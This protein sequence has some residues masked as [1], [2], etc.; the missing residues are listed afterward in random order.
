MTSSA[1]VKV[2]VAGL[3]AEMVREIGLR[4]RDVAISEF[5]NAQQMGRAAAHG[6]AR[7]VILSDVMPTED[8]IYVARRAKDASDDMGIAFLISMQQAENALHALK[9]I[10]VD[11]F[12]LVPVDMEEM[13]LE[14]SKMARVEL[15]PPHESHAEQIASAFFAAWERAKP[16]VFQK[17]DRLDD[18]AISLLDD[19]LSPAQAKAAATEAKSVGESATRFGF[20]VA[21]RIA[22]DVAE[23]FGSATLTAVN[24]LSISEQLLA[25][26][27]NLTGQPTPPTSDAKAATPAPVV[28]LFAETQLEGRRI[29]V[30]D[31]QEPVTRGLTGLLAKRG[32]VVTALNDPLK[33]WRVLENTKPSL[34]LLDL[35]MPKISGV[36]LCRVI[37]NDRRWSELPVIF[38]TG[39]TDQASVNRVFS[40]GADDYI[41]KPFV[42][43]ELMIR[44]ESR[45]TGVKARR[46][47]VE[48]DPLTGL[49]TPLKA[50]ELIERF[51]RLARRKSDPYS[52]TVLQVDAFNSLATSFGRAFSESVLRGIGT[53]LPRSFR[54]EDIPAWWGG[55]D[56]LVGMYGSNK[57]HAAIKVAQICAKIADMNFLA[58]DGR[59]V[60]VACTGGVAE[61]QVDGDSVSALREAAIAAMGKAREAGAKTPVGIAGVKP[62]NPLTRRVDVAIV[63]GDT[64]LVSLLQHAMESRSMRVACYPDGEAAVAALTGDAPEVFAS[65][66]LLG[67]DIP[68]LSGLDVLRRLKSGDVTKSSNVV[69]LTSRTGERDVLA[70]LE[71]GATDH[72]AK[73]F[74]VPVLMHKVRTVLKQGQGA[75]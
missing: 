40:A 73:P 19:K 50:T 45:L 68:A 26:R 38:L 64:A 24:G 2:L 20:Q 42:P 23:R 13:L 62:T 74:S 25:L 29:L 51:L 57:E 54:A 43:A 16:G 39:H 14:L 66:I 36:E 4:L 21:G 53:L 1:P 47:P 46:A 59:R 27:Q 12:F 52:I 75:W 15:L 41:S 65:V 67:V 31:D 69:M 8:A 9:D 70:A 33:F 61:Y 60:H 22:N 3:P 58:E 10:Q 63:D 34:V 5:E 56:F 11:R 6:E 18:A 48:T 72:I 30:V 7:L 71:L 44:I 28:N 37:R 55:P 32:L 17:I 49:A 35:E